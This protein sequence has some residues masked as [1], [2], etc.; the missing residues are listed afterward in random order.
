MLT[1]PAEDYNLSHELD[2]SRYD[3]YVENQ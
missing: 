3:E 1:E 2:S